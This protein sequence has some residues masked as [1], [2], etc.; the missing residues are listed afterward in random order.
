MFNRLKLHALRVFI[1][2]SDNRVLFNPCRSVIYAFLQQCFCR[3]VVHRDSISSQFNLPK[4]VGAGRLSL[5]G[6]TWRI[7]LYT[8]INE[9]RRG[10]FGRSVSGPRGYSQENWVGV[11]GPLPKTLTLFL[12]K[13][14][15]IPYPIYDLTKNRNPIYDLTLKSKPCF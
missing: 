10:D 7:F 1:Y 12:T 14:C 8:C 4:K 6:Q 3:C 9:T 15:D 5:H 13:I 11:C 2:L